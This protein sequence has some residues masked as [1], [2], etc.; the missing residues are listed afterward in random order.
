D[1]S[2][3]TVLVD[4]LHE[5]SALLLLDNMEQVVA[6]APRLAQLLI[7]CPGLVV[8]ATSRG[9]LRITGEQEYPLPP[10]ALPATDT[11]DVDAL[12]ANPS[13]ALFVRR[14]RA[15]RPSFALTDANAAII[16]DICRRLDGL[17]LAIELAAAWAK[18]L[19]P[20]AL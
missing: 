7:A 18:V 13:V 8:L 19:S 2:V 11:R 3:D 4:F 10:L 1:R 15:A 17:P 16:A 14:A 20:P 6:V 9:A 12:A 5:R